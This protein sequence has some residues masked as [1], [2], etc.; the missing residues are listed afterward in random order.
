ME[1]TFDRILDPSFSSSSKRRKEQQQQE[2]LPSVS[3]VGSKAGYVFQTSELGTGYHLD[4]ITPHKNESSTTAVSVA[5]EDVSHGVAKGK[6]AEELLEEAEKAALTSTSTAA[7]L[8]PLGVSQMSAALSKAYERNQLQRSEYFDEPEKYMNSEVD[9]HD[10]LKT[11][12]NVAAAPTLY[13]YL[14]GKQP[15]TSSHQVPQQHQG[16]VRIL[17]QC[18]THP[19]IDIHVVLILKA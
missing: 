18:F 15:T 9:L 5:A 2:F 4:L 3:Y 10:T 1:D 6:T 12:Q 16:A 13:K 19:N 7:T 8:D 17:L 14:Y 11:I